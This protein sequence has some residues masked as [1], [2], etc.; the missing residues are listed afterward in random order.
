MKKLFRESTN[1]ALSNVIDKLDELSDLFLN[2]LLSKHDYSKSNRAFN[3]AAKMAD[4]KALKAMKNSHFIRMNKHIKVFNFRTSSGKYCCTTHNHLTKA[5][6]VNLY[7]AV[8]TYRH[9]VKSNNPGV[10]VFGK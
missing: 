5:E 9:I 3:K 2:D 7:S 1:A 4:R 10:M 8:I 6:S